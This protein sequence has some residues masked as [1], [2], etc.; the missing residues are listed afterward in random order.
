[1]E[2]LLEAMNLGWLTRKIAL[3]LYHPKKTIHYTEINQIDDKT[4]HVKNTDSKGVTLMEFNVK[5]GLKS[6]YQIRNGFWSFI[7]CEV[8]SQVGDALYH[9]PF[10]PKENGII[11]NCNQMSLHF[12]LQPK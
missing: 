5:N 6:Q 8:S 12:H 9:V 7:D 3:R 4:F 10:S 1:M 11:P 2:P